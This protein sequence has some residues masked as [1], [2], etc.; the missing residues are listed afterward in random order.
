MKLHPLLLSSLFASGAFAG[1]TVTTERDGKPTTIA[2]EGNKI[3]IEDHRREK[4]QTMIY[5]GDA[6]K[7]WVVDDAKKTYQEMTPEMMKSMHT[8]MQSAMDNPEVQKRMEQAMANMPPE[9]REQM[10]E[11]MAKR[12]AMMSGDA[13]GPEI[14]YEATG[15]KKKVAGYACT[16]Y[17]EKLDGKPHGRGCYVAWNSAGIKKDDFKAFRSFGDFIAPLA[18]RSG[19]NIMARVEKAPGLPA[20]HVG[21]D[22]EGKADPEVEKLVSVKHG[23]VSAD[24]FK[25]PSD[26]TLEPMRGMGPH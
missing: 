22:A 7:M 10:E 5:D 26:Y 23:S 11:M 12:K 15:E 1:V 20:E 4:A 14:T 2:L 6:Q 16:V 19:E 13:K 21:L 9:R 3:R 18:G 8:Q 25:V 17:T 24:Q